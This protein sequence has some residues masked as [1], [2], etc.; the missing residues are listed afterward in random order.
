MQSQNTFVD[1]N[2]GDAINGNI[3]LYTCCMVFSYPDSKGMPC[4]NKG[5]GDDEYD[6]LMNVVAVKRN[7]PNKVAVFATL[8]QLAKRPSAILSHFFTTALPVLL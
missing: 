8:V 4:I 2:G 6:A 5:G 1:D 3:P 7:E